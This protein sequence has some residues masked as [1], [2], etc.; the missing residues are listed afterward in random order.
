VGEVQSFLQGFA[1][2]EQKGNNLSDFSPEDG[3]SQV[4]IPDP[5]GLFAPFSTADQEVGVEWM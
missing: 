5:T 2:V 3:Q 4:R 1:A